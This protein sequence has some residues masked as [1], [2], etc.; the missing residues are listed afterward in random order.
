MNQEYIVNESLTRMVRKPAQRQQ[1]TTV[2]T[3]CSQVEINKDTQ[4]Y[5]EKGK[6]GQPAQTK[7]DIETTKKVTC[8]LERRNVKTPAGKKPVSKPQRAPAK[9]DANPKRMV[10]IRKDVLD[11]LIN[12]VYPEYKDLKEK[13][14]PQEYLEKQRARDLEKRKKKAVNPMLDVEEEFKSMARGVFEEDELKEKKKKKPHCTKGNV[15]HDSEGRF[16]DKKDAKVFSLQFSKSGKD[17]K[18]GVA[19]MPGQK[20]TKL[21]CGRKSKHSTS[22]AKHKCKNGEKVFEGES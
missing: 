9:P 4:D 16:T 20:F 7:R 17:C 15:Y 3:N 10:Q 13:Q 11:D 22:K 8:D 18:G 2:P 19:R 14:S 1:T 12:R 6:K 21:P 5:I